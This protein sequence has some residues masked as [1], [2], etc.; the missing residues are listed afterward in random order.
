[1]TTPKDDTARRGN[2]GSHKLTRRSAL[3]LAGVG[4]A[5]AGAVTL[6]LWAATT[7]EASPPEAASDKERLSLLRPG[8]AGFAEE[9][10]AFNL[11]VTH[12][13][14][15]IALPRTTEEAAAA[16]R[17][18]A[19]R[20]LPVAVQA[21]GHGIGVPADGALL[22][23]TRHMT[24]VRIDP[25]TRTARIQ[26]GTKWAE[27][28]KAAAE[29]GLAPLVGSAPGVSAIGYVTGGGL[30]VFGRAFGYAADHVRRFS[31]VT[32]NGTVREVSPSRY[33]DLFWGVRGGKSNF[34]LV[35]SM[36]VELFPIRTL[37][38]GTLT[39]PG[40]LAPQ[41]LRA[42]QNWSA[43]LPEKAASEF[44][45]ARMP[46]LPSV[47]EPLRGQLLVN[48]RFAYL[49]SVKDGE[50]LLRPML[51]GQPLANTVKELPHTRIGEVYNDP[52]TP[53]PA[54]E[55][56]GLVRRLDDRTVARLLALAGPG[57]TLPP[58]AVSIRQLGGALSHR[59]RHA[60]AIGH[61]DAGFTFFSAM[62]APPDAG[63]QLRQVQQKL[64]DGMGDVLTG[65]AFPN[66]LN[67]L[68]TTPDAVRAAYTVQDWR[69]LR[70]LKH[71]YDP[72]NT[73][74]INHNIP[75]RG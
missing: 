32:P 56:T 15:A 19:R 3:R 70:Q 47:P 57:V 49:G 35:T 38:G 21:T 11:T 39:Y 30:P 41:L 72:R 23:N 45:L 28:V 10:A 22:V 29:H 71:R 4:G 31:I 7:G 37:Y 6:G 12:D 52:T 61:R 27:V 48:I 53:M 43:R 2:G 13:P 16:V 59:P 62:L 58:G 33:P 75:P 24:G 42:Y 73:F 40:A 69:R 66:F 17:W 46:D 26:A 18:G 60:N 34:G 50:R 36:D 8:D 55:R 64:M 74:R 54:W 63:A 44:T 51:L 68:D 67:S 20:R 65:G 14:E 25:R 5:A 9:K 1:M